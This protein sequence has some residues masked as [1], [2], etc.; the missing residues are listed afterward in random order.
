ME[1][2]WI[3]VGFFGLL[4]FGLLIVALMAVGQ[5][6]DLDE[7]ERWLKEYEQRKNSGRGGSQNE[8]REPEQD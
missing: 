3:T 1:W 8:R 6:T 2:V 4:L 7:E 5:P